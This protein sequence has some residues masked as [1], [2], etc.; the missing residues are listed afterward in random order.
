MDDKNCLK[1]ANPIVFCEAAMVLLLLHTPRDK[2]VG[3]EVLL[4]LDNSVALLQ[5]GE[6]L[7]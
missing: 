3:R 2:L 4:F 5:H 7:L 6:G 1:G